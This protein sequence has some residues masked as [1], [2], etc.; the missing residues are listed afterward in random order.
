MTPWDGVQFDPRR[1][2]AGHVESYFL[3]INDPTGERA[4][5]LKATLLARRG[6]ASAAVA[7]SWAIA[8]E[9][10]R[11]AVAAKATV[12]FATA[13]FA[14]RDLDVET[15]TVSLSRSR[16]RSSL[17]DVA[18][19]LE[20]SDASAPLVHYP[21]RFMYTGPFPSSKFV[22]PMPDLVA[23]GEVRVAGRVWKVDGWRG[24]LGH[25]WGKSHAFAYAWGHCNVWDREDEHVV[26]EG[27]SGRVRVG[28]VLTPTGTLLIVRIGGETHYLSG[29]RRLF[30]N[31]ASM[32]F[33]RW[34]FSGS[35]PTLSVRGEAWAE[36][37]DMV[38]LHYENPDGAMTYCLNSKLASLRLSITPRGGLPLVLSSRAAALE[39]GTRDPSHGVRMIL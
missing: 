24:L 9:R 18:C 37:D 30:L 28:P 20:L 16:A 7:E 29:M 22:S 26:F 15:P 6:E 35:G 8:F 14:A 36:T 13:R 34:R 19:D 1:G 4:L 27:A 33:R 5:W 25:N 12:P 11:P 31:R 17:G 23:R 21:R 10:G 2:A 38:G 32:T 39:I 3:K